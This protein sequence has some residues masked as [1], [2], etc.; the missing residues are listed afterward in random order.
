MTQDMI[1]RINAL[2]AKSRTEAGLTD[3]EKTEQASLRKA[4]VDSIKGS[5]RAQLD[6]TDIVEPDGTITPLK[7]KP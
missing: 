1:A 6:N 3:E 2:A 4:Y 5:L 7:Q